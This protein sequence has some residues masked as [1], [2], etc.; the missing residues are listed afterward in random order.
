M[1]ATKETDG[2]T[3]LPVAADC[4]DFLRFKASDAGRADSDMVDQGKANSERREG[5]GGLGGKGVV[6]GRLKSES[7]LKIFSSTMPVENKVEK[8]SQECQSFIVRFFLLPATPERP[9]VS[10][11][12][13]KISSFHSEFAAPPFTP[14]PIWETT[15][16]SKEVSMNEESIYS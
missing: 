12:Q 4:S 6:W 13:E 15:F 2:R 9:S 7:V 1:H 3:E 10:Q 8:E 11:K 16:C 5:Q 14:P